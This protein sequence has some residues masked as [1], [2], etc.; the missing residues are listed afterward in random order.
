MALSAQELARYSRHILLS[1]IGGDGQERLRAGRIVVVGAGGLGSPALLYLAAAG[2]GTLG[3]I[4]CDEVELSNLQRQV[5]YDSRDVAQAKASAAQ[6]RLAGLNPEIAVIAHAVELTAGNAREILSG[7]DVVVDGCDRISTR[8]L[9]ND[10]CVLLGK[11]LVSAAIHKFE[12]Q[13]LTYVP[14]RGPCYRCLFP[15]PPQADIPTCAQAGVLG[16]L[17]GVLGAI[18]AT[19]ALKILLG[20]GELLVG[21]LLTFDALEMRFR[22]FP[23][24][25][26]SDCPVCGERPSITGLDQ[27]NTAPDPHATEVRH[28]SAQQLKSLMSATAD[29]RP[30]IVDVRETNEFAAGHLTGAINIPLGDIEIRLPEL[31]ASRLTVFVC[32]SGKR[33]EHAC[34]IAARSGITAAAHLEGGL[35]AWNEGVDRSLKIE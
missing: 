28:L 17:P 24:Q 22:E 6:R 14:G 18:Q 2:V 34:V 21:R 29:R 27:Q 19:E 32:R 23:F 13:A 1:E 3:L 16:V 20:V 5:L 9:V 10:A 7:Y 31:A 26:R 11:P 4:D 8:Y 35:V 30:A 12:G 25:R 15:Q 33:S